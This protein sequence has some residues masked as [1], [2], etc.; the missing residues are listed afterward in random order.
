MCTI[1]LKE[2]KIQRMIVK[3]KKKKAYISLQQI[4]INKK[5]PVVHTSLY[6]F[7]FIANVFTF[8][9]AFLLTFSFLSAPRTTSTHAGKKRRFE[10]NSGR[11]SVE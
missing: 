11:T 7:I 4:I 6:H 2:N 3:I 5:K 8:F 1:I 9:E 10:S